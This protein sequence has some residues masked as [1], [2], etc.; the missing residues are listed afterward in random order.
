M[1]KNRL[2]LL[3][4]KQRSGAVLFCPGFSFFLAKAGSGCYNK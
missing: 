3:C 4:N 2:G 1:K